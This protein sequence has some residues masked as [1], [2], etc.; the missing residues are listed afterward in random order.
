MQ[1]FDITKGVMEEIYAN[2]D[3]DLRK[4][5]IDLHN[6]VVLPLRAI[7]DAED[8]LEGIS[9]EK[10]KQWWDALEQQRRKRRPRP[11]M[12]GQMAF[13]F[14][15]KLP[16]DTAPVQDFD[17]RAEDLVNKIP[18]ATNKTE[19]DS[20]ID[21]AM[22]NPKLQKI[23]IAALATIVGIVGNKYMGA[24]PAL[25]GSMI[26]AIVSLAK[27]KMQGKTANDALQDIGV[28]AALGA[29]GGQL[30]AAAVTAS[31]M[32]ED[33]LP[34]PD[35]I[36]HGGLSESKLSLLAMLAEAEDTD[37]TNLIKK[38]YLQGHTP[39][40]IKYILIN[41]FK[42]QR[43]VP[44]VDKIVAE[45]DKDRGTTPDSGETEQNPDDTVMPPGPI[46]AAPVKAEPKPVVKKIKKKIKQPINL[47]ST[48]N[49]W[50]DKRLQDKY[51]KDGREAAME[52]ADTLRVQYF[53]KLMG[54]PGGMEM[55][56][57][58]LSQ[59]QAAAIVK[60]LEKEGITEAS[61]AVDLM[62][63]IDREFD[64]V[65]AL[66][67]ALARM[68]PYQRAPIMRD[69]RIIANLP[70][71]KKPSQGQLPSPKQTIKLKKIAPTVA[72]ASPAVPRRSST[73]KASSRNP[74][75]VPQA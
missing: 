2:S 39:S 19:I 58:T 68:D 70:A 74:T 71:P 49:P 75:Q 22:G 62:E 63:A 61:D 11:P 17:D 6:T 42:A 67:L 31:S 8:I 55:V 25:L 35:E 20:L 1:G 32:M 36:W 56:V 64:M 29:A 3:R 41:N 37:Y 54:M 57:P 53:Y 12:D 38:A 46:S 10:E 9:P 44:L 27:A 16:N 43:W 7:L 30:G 15:N 4:H 14:Y 65:K 33:M 66:A 23:A 52:Y 48:G 24:N 60:A 69:L 18:N 5:L 13:D 51:R 28:S 47:P 40:D 26:S 59:Q 73:R 72:P 21:T 45:I 50:I 34:E